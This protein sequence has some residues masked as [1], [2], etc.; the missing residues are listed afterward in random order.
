MDYA[1]ESLRRHAQWKGKI[2]I[3]VKV[4]DGG[5]EGLVLSSMV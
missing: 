2:E 5:E 3:T 4:P 1:Q